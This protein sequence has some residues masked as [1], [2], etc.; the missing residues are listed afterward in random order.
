MNTSA[1]LSKLRHRVAVMEHVKLSPGITVTGLAKRMKLSESYINKV[2]N[3]LHDEGKLT[4]VWNNTNGERP[5][6]KKG[7]H[8]SA[9]EEKPHEPKN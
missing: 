4:W 1:E 7:W 2:L 8:I 6:Y 5:P 3:T 9:I